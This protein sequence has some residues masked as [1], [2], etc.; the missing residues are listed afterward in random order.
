MK[1]TMKPVEALKVV[2]LEEHGLNVRVKVN[3]KPCE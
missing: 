2:T 3:G 1:F